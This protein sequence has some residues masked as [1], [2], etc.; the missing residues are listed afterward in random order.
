M[1]LIVSDPISGSIY[2]TSL[3]SLDLVPVLAHNNHCRRAPCPSS[4]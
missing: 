2:F 3:Y 1:V 4:F